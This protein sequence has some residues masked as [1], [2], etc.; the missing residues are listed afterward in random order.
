MQL[1]ITTHNQTSDCKFHFY[2]CALTRNKQIIHPFPVD[3][4]HNIF[5][6]KSLAEIQ[7]PI[8]FLAL[9][10]LNP[11]FL[12]PNP[13][14]SIPT[15]QSPILSP[16]FSIL[17]PQSSI[18]NLQSPIPNPQFSMLNSHPQKL[19]FQWSRESV[20]VLITG[21]QL[22]RSRSKVKCDSWNPSSWWT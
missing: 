18:L 21:E 15:P 11:Q 19:G 17:N 13:Q 7:V 22:P 3:L 6:W 14:S 9:P 16:Q 10:I 2:R 5:D 8:N 20:S 1:W 4:F 12:I